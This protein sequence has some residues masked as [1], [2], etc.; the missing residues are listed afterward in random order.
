M[1]VHPDT[2]LIVAEARR[3]EALAEAAQARLADAVVSTGAA[4][5]PDRERL[6]FLLRAVWPPSPLV[7][8]PILGIGGRARRRQATDPEADS[9]A[10]RPS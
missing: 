2:M 1:A 4:A 3:L 8:F 7:S 6:R 5:A 9:L 10:R